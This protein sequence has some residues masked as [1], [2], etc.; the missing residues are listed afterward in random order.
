MSDKTRQDETK[1]EKRNKE[2]LHLLERFFNPSVEHL[3]S[4]YLEYTNCIEL[5]SQ[6]QDQVPDPDEDTGEPGRLALRY[7]QDK[8]REVRSLLFPS[9]GMGARVIA[10]WQLLHRISEEM[11][12]LMT[13]EEL[14]GFGVRLKRQIATT[15]IQELVAKEWKDM[16]KSHL[17]KIAKEHAPPEDIRETR[18][19]F[20]NIYRSVNEV[21]DN[22]FWD[23]WAKKFLAFGY[24]IA[25][26]L[27]TIIFLFGELSGGPCLT[28]GK[29]LLLGAMGGLMSGVFTSAGESLPKGHF[30]IP[31]LYYLL[32]RPLMGLLAALVIFWS[33]ESQFLVAIEPPYRE[34]I[35]ACGSISKEH[36]GQN[37]PEISA[38]P[39]E[40]TKNE[41]T[42][43]ISPVTMKEKAGKERDEQTAPEISAL[44]PETTKNEET[45]KIQTI[46][47]KA[48]AGKEHYLY[49]LL[50]LCAGFAGDKLLKAIADR[51]TAKLINKAEKTKENKS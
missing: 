27:L 5:L 45:V 33:V 39:P 24:T 9:T 41:G 13:R 51:V 34:T 42:V 46:T 16:V 2:S 20:K 28:L 8:L 6:K 48:K 36:G 22:R 3:V 18:Q 26:T 4:K 12:L 19:I 23:L 43:K 31:T 30:W 14:L 17:A 1:T 15:A 21:V 40:T 49:M 25:L 29:I 50:F 44:P 11:I 10:A 37:I 47:M 35:V 7:C 32:V 38:L